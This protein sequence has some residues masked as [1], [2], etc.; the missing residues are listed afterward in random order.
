ML[1]VLGVTLAQCSP[2]FPLMSFFFSRTPHSVGLACPL[3]PPSCDSSSALPGLSWPWHFWRVGVIYRMLPS[4]CFSDVF[5]WW[6][7]HYTF[8]ARISQKWCSPLSVSCQGYQT[9]LYPIT[10]DA[11]LDHLIWAGV[12]WVT[13]NSINSKVTS[14]PHLIYKYLEGA[15]LRLQVSCL[16]SNLHARISATM[17]SEAF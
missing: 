10:S 14:F 8:L 2:V 4:L 6:N 7:R 12:C 3:S 15:T 11:N 13:F 1:Y 9:S 5:S 16:S 17:I